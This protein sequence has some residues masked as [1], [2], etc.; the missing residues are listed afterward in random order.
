[1]IN[2]VQVTWISRITFNVMQVTG[3]ATNALKI[4]IRE[5][6]FSNWFDKLPNVSKLEVSL[7]SF[8]C[9]TIYSASGRNSRK[10]TQKDQ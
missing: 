6:L 4:L 1:M 10:E 7:V 5:G 3:A 9:S 8:H 2:I